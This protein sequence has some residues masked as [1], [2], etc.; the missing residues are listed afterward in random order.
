MT[1]WIGDFIKDLLV[2]VLYATPK[3]KN[4]IITKRLYHY[5]M[6]TQ[7]YSQKTYPWILF[8]PKMKRPP[9]KHSPLPPDNINTNICSH[10]RGEG[11]L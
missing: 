9:V 2:R 1:N 4:K 7:T 3:E 5:Y 6:K 8:E 11:S 10:R